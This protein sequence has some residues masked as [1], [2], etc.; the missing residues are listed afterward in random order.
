MEQFVMNILDMKDG[1]SVV[2]VRSDTE[3]LT[4]EQALSGDILV[5]K[6]G[7]NMNVLQR[8]EG[9]SNNFIIS[10]IYAYLALEP[11]GR[12]CAIEISSRPYKK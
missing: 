3:N 5:V 11:K 2:E 8:P 4:A 9:I 10:V 6:T 1:N 12:P 7:P